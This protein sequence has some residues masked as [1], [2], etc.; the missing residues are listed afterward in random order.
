MYYIT[1]I[2]LLVIHCN[3]AEIISP[4]IKSKLNENNTEFMY[5]TYME[6]VVVY[7]TDCNTELIIGVTNTVYLIN[8]TDKSNITIDFSPGNGLTQLG[9][10]YITFIGQFNNKTLVC[11]TNATSPACW[12]INGTTKE[13]SPYGRGFAPEGYD[14]SGLVLIDGEEVYSTIKKYTHLSTGFRR[15]VGNPALYTSSSTMKNPRFVH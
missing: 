3:I 12:Y 4:R 7:H 9:A 10:N 5:R 15:I 1:I 13:P 8:I 11:G 2:I 6:D 14:M